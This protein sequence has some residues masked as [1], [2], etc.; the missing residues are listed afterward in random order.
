MIYHTKGCIDQG[1]TEQEILEA[2]GVSAAFG[3]RC[4]DESVRLTV[5]SKSLFQTDASHTH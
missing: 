4:S 3:C 5:L 2:C 1:A